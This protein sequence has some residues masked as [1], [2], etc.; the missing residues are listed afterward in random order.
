MGR[1]KY[2]QCGHYLFLPWLSR[3]FTYWQNMRHRG[4][5]SVRGWNILVWCGSSRCLCVPT[6]LLVHRSE[7]VG[8]RKEAVSTIARDREYHANAPN[9]QGLFLSPS[10]D[11]RLRGS[12]AQGPTAAWEGRKRRQKI[13]GRPILVI[14]GAV[15]IVR[16]GQSSPWTFQATT[17]RNS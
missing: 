5:Q 11:L 15:C 1:V 17:E 13:E 10:D 8:D 3:R 16:T 9:T 2:S 7:I 4:R 12:S 14:K 6:V